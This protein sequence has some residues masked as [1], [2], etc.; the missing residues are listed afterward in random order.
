MIRP[1]GRP[2]V[3]AALALLGITAGTRAQVQTPSD[4]AEVIRAVARNLV[5]GYVYESTGRAAADSLERALAAGGFAGLDGEALARRITE[6]LSWASNDRHLGVSW[7]GPDNT[8]AEEP[9]EQPAEPVPAQPAE[10]EAEG[11]EFDPRDYGFEEVAV[12]GGGIGYLNLTGFNDDPKA[13]EYAD[14]VMA[15]L[16]SVTALI[17]DL[18]EN[19]GGGPQMVRLVSTYLFDEPTHLVSTF[20]RG[21]EAPRERWTLDSVKGKRLSIPVYL[22]TSRSTLSAA[23][24]FAFGLKSNGRVTIVGER[25]K[26]GG[27]F[28]EWID[29]PGGFTMFLPQGRTYDPRTNRGWEAEG[30]EPDV[31]VPAAEALDTALRLIDEEREES[32]VPVPSPSSSSTTSR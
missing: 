25:T 5:E 7:V 19:T 1:L 15:S 22:L 4:P 16:A 10:P 8:P 2:I 28:G 27:H 29:L 9:S 18:R 20:I 26:G 3:L 12:L 14:S 21:M 30:I 31:H 6:I 17:I 24:S 32:Y 11:D 23:E 13:L